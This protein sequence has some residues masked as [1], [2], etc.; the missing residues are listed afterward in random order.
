MNVEDIASKSSVVFEM[1]YTHGWNDTISGI[2]VHVSPGSAETLVGNGE[3]TNHH[4]IAYSL[5]NV[6]AKN[7][8]N[9]FM[10]VEVIVCNISVVFLGHSVLTSA[11]NHTQSPNL[12]Q[13]MLVHLKNCS[14]E[15]T[16][17]SPQ[18]TVVH[19]TA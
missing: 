9:R 17:D 5:S 12:K 3:I 4:L 13:Q 8:R 11:K 19:N 7:Y 14:C 6:S 15:C 10:C 1:R 16:Y 2:H 18:L